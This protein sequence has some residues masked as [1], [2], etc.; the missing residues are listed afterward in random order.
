MISSHSLSKSTIDHSPSDLFGN[1]PN[2]FNIPSPLDDFPQQLH[3]FTRTKSSSCSQLSNPSFNSSIS[4]PYV[5]ESS[6][7]QPM[8]LLISPHPQSQ[9]LDSPFD[10]SASFSEPAYNGPTAEPQIHTLNS[11]PKDSFVVSP[12]PQLSDYSTEAFN[13]DSFANFN[14]Y[15]NTSVGAPP[16]QSAQPNPQ[17]RLLNCKP[18]LTHHLLYTTVATSLFTLMYVWRQDYLDLNTRDSS[19]ESSLFFF[20]SSSYLLHTQSR[21]YKIHSH[22]ISVLV[23]LSV[24]PVQDV[25]GFHF[26]WNVNKS[27]FTPCNVLS[28]LPSIPSSFLVLP[29]EDPFDSN[30][31]TVQCDYAS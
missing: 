17:S 16:V 13:W 4:P 21:S 3:G 24:F 15:D 18:A 10:L 2:N 7:F 19:L 12:Q 20:P 26:F 8:Q 11:P 23:L 6:E 1:S 28:F 29:I 31:T 22:L 5:A 27:F 14:S 25:T 9:L 30:T